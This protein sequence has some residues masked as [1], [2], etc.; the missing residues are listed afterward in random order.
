MTFPLLTL[1]AVAF[2]GVVG[3]G[4]RYFP[5]QQ[6]DF[7]MGLTPAPW[8]LQVLLPAAGLAVFLLLARLGPRVMRHSDEHLQLP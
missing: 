4:T 6:G 1:M 8:I 3:F 7:G 5:P 2:F